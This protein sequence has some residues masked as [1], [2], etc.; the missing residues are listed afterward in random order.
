[1]K[2]IYLLEIGSE[3]N[4]EVFVNN[5][6]LF[7]TKK[8]AKDYGENFLKEHVDNYFIIYE[9]KQELSNKDE[10]AILMRGITDE[11]PDVVSMIQDE[12]NQI[13]YESINKLQKDNDNLVVEYVG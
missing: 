13:A 8:R 2:T 3:S 11:D 4:N 10:E 6:I 5:N 12:N 9:S 1:M 7:L